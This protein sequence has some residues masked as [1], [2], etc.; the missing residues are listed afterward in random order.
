MR[1]VGRV[2]EGEVD[3]RVL[4]RELAGV[5]PGDVVARGRGRTRRLCL[6]SLQTSIVVPE[7]HI[8]SMTVSP[9]V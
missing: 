2:D 8:G 9:R 7:P 5:G 6:R 4:E 3:G 1:R